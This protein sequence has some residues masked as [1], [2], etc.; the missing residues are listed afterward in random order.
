MRDKDEKPPTVDERV[1]P[2][3]MESGEVMK[4]VFT[5]LDDLKPPAW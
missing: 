3:T 4:P 2:I 5:S 1:I